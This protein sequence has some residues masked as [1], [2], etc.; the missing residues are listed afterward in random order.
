MKKIYDPAQVAHWVEKEHI[1]DYFDTPNLTFSLSVYDKGEYLSA[2][3][4]PMEELLFLVSGTVQIYGIYGDGSISP[5]NQF[6]C[7]A[8]LG[9]LEFSDC[10][11]PS[12]YAAAKTRA[13]C[14][15]LSVQTYRAQLDRDVTFLHMLLRSYAEKLRLFSNLDAASATLEEKVLLFLERRAPAHELVGIESATLQLHCSR[16]QL[17]RV[18]AKLCETGQLEKTGKGRYRL[19][20][21]D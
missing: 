6:T 5:I 2:P 21:R 14:V 9:D 13:V 10:E 8:V 12:F 11:N 7:P 1:L 16:R 17:Q 15:C 19:T 20:A 18:L 4:R 3:D